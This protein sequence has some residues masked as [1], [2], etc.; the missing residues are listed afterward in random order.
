V[1]DAPPSDDL[2]LSVRDVSVTFDRRAVLSDVTFELRRGDRLAIIGPNGS[3]KTVL[4]KAILGLVPHE[5]TVELRAG[6][7][8][9]YVPQR[10]DADR[11]L[12]LSARNVLHAKARVIRCAPSA[13]ESAILRVGLTTDVL[14][15]PIW[16][17]S[18]G[19]FQR[20]LI[21]FAILGDPELIILDEPTTSID[22]PGEE[23]MF[24]LIERLQSQ[25]HVGTII[26]SH[27]LSL[28]HRRTNHA[29]C[30]NRS[31][32]CFVPPREALTAE[33]LEK[34]FTAP[35]PEPAPRP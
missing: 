10:T 1:I 21:A 25:M 7:R 15:R 31:G 23:K 16:Q 11:N 3:G 26:V 4:L 9:G 14:S 29:L 6:T 20:V 27:D 22:E 34:L 17:L 18:G 32:R 28:I 24:D 30:I 19:E 8:I 35:A 12:P 5:G 33:M 13:I 2:L